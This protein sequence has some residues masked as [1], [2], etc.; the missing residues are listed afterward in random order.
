MRSALRRLVVAALII[1]ALS[2]IVGCGSPAPAAVSS[3]AALRHLVNV[4]GFTLDPG[5]TYRV[6]FDVDAPQLR[7][8]GMVRGREASSGADPVL[9]CRL[10]KVSGGSGRTPVT[11]RARFHP[12]GSTWIYVAETTAPL[13]PGSYQLVLSGDCRLLAF[14]AAQL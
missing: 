6:T 1:A 10:D 8:L 2:A 4:N 3:P 12:G 9:S 7:I 5:Q 13:Q 14:G 11:L